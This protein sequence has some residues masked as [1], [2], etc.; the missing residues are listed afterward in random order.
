MKDNKTSYY[1]MIISFIAI[2]FVLITLVLVLQGEEQEQKIDKNKAVTYEPARTPSGLTY[3]SERHDI[4]LWANAQV[5]Y[6]TEGSPAPISAYHAYYGWSSEDW[7]QL[8]INW[9]GAMVGVDPNLCN[10]GQFACPGGYNF[11]SSVNGEY[12]LSGDT[13][14]IMPGWLVYEFYPEYCSVAPSHVGIYTGDGWVHGNYLEY[15]VRKPTSNWG[16]LYGYAKPF[17]RSKVTYIASYGNYPNGRVKGAGSYQE[18]FIDERSHSLTTDVSN[19]NH[20]F[21]GWYTNSSASGSPIN[22]ISV[23]GGSYSTGATVYAGWKKLE[24]PISYVTYG[25]TIND[26]TYITKYLEGETPALPMNVTRDGCRFLGW[27]LNNPPSGTAYSNVQ[28]NWSGAL[29]LYAKYE[30]NISYVLNR[31]E[32]ASG[33]TPPTT[34]FPRVSTFQLP[35]PP[36]FIKNYCDFYGWYT[37]S[38]FNSEGYYVVRNDDTAPWN[39]DILLHAKWIGRFYEIRLHTRG[40]T[41]SNDNYTYD[42]D[43]DLYKKDYQFVDDIPSIPFPTKDEVEKSGYAFDGWYDSIDF[44]G[45]TCTETREGEGGD[46]DIYARWTTVNP[47]TTNSEHVEIINNM[48]NVYVYNASREKQTESGPIRA[49]IMPIAKAKRFFDID[50]NVLG[51]TSSTVSNDVRVQVSTSKDPS[52]V[53]PRQNWTMESLSG[54]SCVK[55]N[56]MDYV[57]KDNNTVRVHLPS[58]VEDF[59]G[60]KGSRIIYFHIVTGMG[61]TTYIPI[62]LVNRTVY[63]M[64]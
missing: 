28:A 62:N 54:K 59:I 17:Y 40:G 56:A 53:L 63:G 27:S 61:T 39:K 36:N 20:R 5:G 2:F 7:C 52:A 37:D 14:G 13:N 30:A 12:R 9:L 33:Y 1:N 16:Q 3:Q 31:G 46:Y 34:Y 8:F 11:Y 21:L 45:N 4:V 22:Q 18:Y 42:S 44:A 25:G 26:A 15:Y 57:T 29:T 38:E 49:E 43:R 55:G 58:N 24:S 50:I 6:S 51:A 64:Y 47:N 60:D 48:M 10:Q 23:P 35:Q 32:Y 19:P 41:V